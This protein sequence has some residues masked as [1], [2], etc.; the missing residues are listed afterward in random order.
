MAKKTSRPQNDD[1][2]HAAA[3]KPRRSRARAATDAG[4]EEN[5]A[6][7]APTP[8]AATADDRPAEGGPADSM[9]SEPSEEDI[10]LRAYHRYLERGAGHGAHF[11]DWLEAERELKQRR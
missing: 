9:S 4:G 5:A 10:R 2:T 11:D 3:P 8:P 7:V 6:I 1:P